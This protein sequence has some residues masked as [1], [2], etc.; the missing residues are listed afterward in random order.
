MNNIDVIKEYAKLNQVPIINDEGLAFLLEQINKYQVKEVLELGTAIAYSA[1]MMAENGAN[2]TTIER[3]KEMY[4][5]AIKNIADL[6]LTTKINVVYKDALDAFADVAN[7][8][9]D[10]L[11]ID[12]AKAQ[13]EKFFNLY[14][15]L[16][17]KGGIIICDN[18]DFHGL[19]ETDL[20]QYK[21]HLRQ[22]LTKIKNFRTFLVNNPNYITTIYKIGDGLSLS[23]KK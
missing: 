13:Y 2:V 19:V 22:M 12:A 10:M 1:I 17:K 18:L 11:F 4:D 8:E 23:I 21:R 15:P 9:Y 7:K 3:D 5:Q 16:L 14:T 6:G 20:T